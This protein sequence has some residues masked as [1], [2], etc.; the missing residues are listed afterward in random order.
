MS[1]QKPHEVQEGEVKSSAPGEGNI[2]GIVH[3]GGCPAAEQVLLSSGSGEAIVLLS[4][5][6]IVLSTRGCLCP[7][8]S[9]P[10][11]STSTRGHR[12]IGGIPMDVHRDC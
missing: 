4:T 1:C 3:A 5:C 11:E 9:S 8:L 2:P 10:R 7:A 12:Y 6:G